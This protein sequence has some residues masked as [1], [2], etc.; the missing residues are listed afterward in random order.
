[1]KSWQV[2]L[3][4]SVCILTFFLVYAPHLQ[5]AFPIHIDEWH[6]IQETLK[7]REGNYDWGSIGYRI[8]FHVFLLTLSLFFNLVTIY[9]FLPALWAVLSGLVL[10]Y[11]VYKKTSLFP[12]A[13]AA[14]FFFA[15]IKSNVNLTGIWFFTSLSFSIPFIFLYFYFFTEGL[16]QQNKRYLLLSFLLMFLLIFIHSIS[17]LFAVPALLVHLIFYRVY[18]KKE[19]AF[20]SLFLLIPLVGLLFYKFMTGVPFSSLL[21][22]VSAALQFHY[23][24]GVLELKNSFLEVYSWIG[25]LFAILGFIILTY[26]SKTRKL[27]LAYLAWPVFML[28]DIYIYRWTGTSYLSPYQRNMYYFA[29][30]MPLLSAYGLY[31]T[32]NAINKKLVLLSWRSFRYLILSFLLFMVMFF[33]LVAYYYVPE[34]IT[35]Y[36]LV[37]PEDLPALSYL[38]TLSSG[39]VMAPLDVSSTLYPLTRHDPVAAIYF[40][41]NR[42]DVETFFSGDCS[43]KESLLRTY[44]VAYVFSRDPIYCGWD[45]LYN[46]QDYIYKTPIRLLR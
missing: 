23:G 2:I 18:L 10:F 13:L 24:W 44:K 22:T 5:N 31:Y 25:Y 43:T 34:N 41:G 17:L 8:G 42:N 3:I 26:L 46:T 7:L 9:P 19:Y 1:M 45:V 16:E 14:M 28:L 4:V 33:S 36:N 40:Y 35:L 37:N 20:F 21:A 38:S 27:Y 11:V 39:K 32:F 6:H 29:L 15:T 12:L 30:A